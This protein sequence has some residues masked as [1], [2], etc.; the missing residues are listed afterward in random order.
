M[1]YLDVKDRMAHANLVASLCDLEH[2]LS[3]GTNDK[4]QLAG[5]VGL[6]QVSRSAL[7]SA[8]GAC[9]HD[10]GVSGHVF[11]PQRLCARVG[12]C[13][14]LRIASC[15]FRVSCVLAYPE[16]AYARACTY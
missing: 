6:F 13:G 9:H 5:M 15:L 12:G 4:M 14:R 3:L 2:R 7:K 11:W 8:Y 16:T 1:G 10:S